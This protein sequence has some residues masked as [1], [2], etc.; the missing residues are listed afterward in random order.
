MSQPSQSVGRA[1]VLMGIGTSFSRISGF[2]RVAIIAWAIGGVESKLPDTYQLANTLPNIVYQL[3]LGEILATI[4]VPIFVEHLTKGREE[5]RKLSSTILAVAVLGAG[6]FAL[7]T[8]LA[9]PWLIKIYTF[10]LT[11]ADRVAQEQVGAFFLRL[12]MP[13]MIFYA[14]HSILAGLLDAHGRFGAPR[15]VPILNNVIVS[16]TFIAFRF[17]HGSVQPTLESLTTGD[18]LLLGLGTTTGVAFLVIGLIPAVRR[19]PGWFSW[20]A[21]DWRHPAL[22]RVATLAK[23]SL[24]YVIVNQ[25]GHWVVKALANGV[26]GGVAAYDNSFTLFQLPYGIVAVSVFSALV[27]LLSRHSQRG[28]LDSFRHDLRL[29]LRMSSF[30]VLPASAGLIALSQPLMRVL[31][32]HG[33]FSARSTRLFADT[34]AYMAIGLWAYAMFQ[35]LMRAFYSMQDTRTPTIVNS[36][37][38][39]VNVVTALPFFY[40][41]GVPG[42]GLSQSIS[43][44][45]ALIYGVVVMRSRVG[46]LGGRELGG[47]LLRVGMASLATGLAAWAVAGALE[48]AIDVSNLTG[49]IIQVTVAIA[50]GVAV[51]VALAAALKIE[52]LRRALRMAGR[53]LGKAR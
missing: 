4:F 39:A 10:R 7:I 12:F 46:S 8:I 26:Q 1:T 25:V 32:E 27:P 6:A 50:A 9:A 2:V 52:E 15:F 11:G 17:S 20:K 29:G 31:L 37:G 23:W 33:V 45:L 44:L 16:A 51:Y 24:V 47:W 53:L 40:L 13:Q 38:V 43:Y 14:T 41:M 5:T 34:F 35:Q 48:S 3:V 36:A 30:I 42:L 22:R 18:K 21:I 49:Q 28:D 19:L